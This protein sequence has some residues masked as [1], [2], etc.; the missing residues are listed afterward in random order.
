MR[1]D[2]LPR[3]VTRFAPAPTGFLHLGHIVNAI[4][5]WGMTRL[6]GG[7]VLLRI[8][9]HDR[10]RSRPEFERAILDDLAWL[11]LVPD[12]TLTRQSD[13]LALYGAAL[14]QLGSRVY[15]CACSRRELAA[16]GD[17]TPGDELRYD[18]RCRERN[19]AWE[20]GYG[21]RVRLDDGGERFDDLLLGRQE[22]HPAA[23]CGDLLIRDR[24][25]NWT[26]QFA[27]TVDDLEQNISLVI[28]GQD[29][30]PSTG[31]QI[32]LA[33]L[34]GRP[35]P[36]AFLHHPLLYRTDGAKLSKSNRDSGVRELREAGYSPTQVIA[37]AARAVGL[38]GP[39]D[40]EEWDLILRKLETL[41]LYESRR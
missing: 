19:L 11:G 25:G 28:R 6:A 35:A 5:V 30:L 33:R 14:E 24:L 32:A 2:R 18:G 27:V 15:A 4:H 20:P 1:T 3:L 34:L 22:Q 41:P 38:I 21:L 29:L 7:T 8:E 31:R 16:E 37:Q 40:P 39:G 26:Y 23:Q 12:G 13:R 9:D 36:A 10:Q 17:T